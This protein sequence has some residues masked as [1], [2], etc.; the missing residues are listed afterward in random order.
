MSSTEWR[1]DEIEDSVDTDVPFGDALASLAIDTDEDVD[2]VA[3]VRES[4]EK[5]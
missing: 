1:P 2:P 5:I 4:R 3:A